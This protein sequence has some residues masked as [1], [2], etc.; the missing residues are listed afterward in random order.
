MVLSIRDITDFLETIAPMGLAE[1]WDN[2]GLLLGRPDQEV[3]SVLIGLDPSLQLLD[4]AIERG[5]DLIITHHPIIFHPL[6]SI[7][8]DAPTGIFIQRALE[9][10]IAVIG[11][12]TNFDSAQ[13]G[14]SDALAA[15]LG[16]LDTSPLVPGEDQTGLGRIGLLD[17]PLS[18]KAFSDLLFDVLCLP[19]LM[20]AGK[21]PE[22]ISR[23]A[24]C[25][26]SGSELA[27]TAQAM[28]ADLYLSAEIK[29]STARWAEDAG[30]CII[31]GT[32]Y[33]TEFPLVELLAAKLVRHSTTR[34]W[35]IDVKQTKRETPPFTHINRTTGEQP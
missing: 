35:N 7:A 16:L 9:H 32:H 6:K 12:H 22:Q 34:G 21:L 2:V 18:S 24:V 1:S 20:V 8:T 14:V 23:V 29:H 3:H 27:E 5:C 19:T 26:G 17:P 30:F 13:D 4:E 10:K 25:G 33:A 28:G 31:D 11:C 15:R